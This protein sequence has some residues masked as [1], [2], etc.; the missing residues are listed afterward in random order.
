MKKESPVSTKP[1][2]VVAPSY[3]RPVINP[4]DIIKVVL[5]TDLTVGGLSL[6]LLTKFITTMKVRQE[7]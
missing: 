6:T 1:K 3:S 5:S 7:N 4:D 2:T